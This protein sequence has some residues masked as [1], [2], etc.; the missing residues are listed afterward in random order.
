MN[1]QAKKVYEIARA[2]GLETLLELFVGDLEEFAA[3]I[4]LNKDGAVVNKIL[5]FV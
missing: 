4:D 3:G 5:E 1:E 2:A